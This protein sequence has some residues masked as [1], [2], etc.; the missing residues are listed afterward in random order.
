MKATD[1]PKQTLSWHSPQAVTSKRDADSVGAG[2]PANTGTA[3]AIHR[4][5][6]FAGKPAPTK[7]AGESYGSY[8]SLAGICD[9]YQ[10]AS[11]DTRF[12]P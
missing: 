1:D 10:R 8:E 7:D 4:G 5:A 2:L 9:L 11:S 12:Y 6:G 3:G